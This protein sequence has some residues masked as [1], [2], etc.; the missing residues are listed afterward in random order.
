MNHMARWG[1]GVNGFPNS[2]SAIG[3]KFY[4][5]DDQQFPDT[6]TCAF[7]WDAIGKEQ[8]QR[9]LIFEM[10]I[11]SKNRPHNVDSGVEFY[12][13]AGM[14]M[15]SKR[16]K[17]Q[18]WDDDNRL[19][20]DPKP[21]ERPDAPK[22]HQVDFLQ[23]IRDQR[24][25]SADIEIGHDSCVPIH[26]ANIAVRTGRPIRLDPATQTIV[27]DTEAEQLLGRTYRDGGHWGV[28]TDRAGS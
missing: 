2:A 25:P 24:K 11:W 10:R 19:V 28:P 9:Q 13:T 21:R 12:G 7:Q 4:F 15:V 6:A 17:L 20:P 5:D 23:A 1:L 14:L 16:R 8:P 26:L 18:V 22:N 27:D 3:G